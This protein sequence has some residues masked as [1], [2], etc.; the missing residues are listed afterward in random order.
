MFM[1]SVQEYTVRVENE[2][3]KIEDSNPVSKTVFN[4]GNKVKITIQEESI[5]IL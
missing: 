5:H 3:L 1:G 2:I 4:E